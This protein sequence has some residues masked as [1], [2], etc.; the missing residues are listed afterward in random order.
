MNTYEDTYYN[1]T[2]LEQAFLDYRDSEG[3]EMQDIPQRLLEPFAIKLFTDTPLAGDKGKQDEILDTMINQRQTIQ[4]QYD[5]GLIDD[6]Y[7]LELAEIWNNIHNPL[8]D[9]ER[10][11]MPQMQGTWDLLDNI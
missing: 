4:Q 11:E 9:Y 6:D 2:R 7:M 3:L 1:C 5:M 8:Q 10:Q